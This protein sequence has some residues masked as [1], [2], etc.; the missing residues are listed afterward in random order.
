MKV[1]N[2]PEPHK[3]D[4]TVLFMLFLV[5][6]SFHL[7]MERRKS[8]V[9]II[10]L[11]LVCFVFEISKKKHKETSDMQIKLCFTVFGFKQ[12]ILFIQFKLCLSRSFVSGPYFVQLLCMC[13]EGMTWK[14]CKQSTHDI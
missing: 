11:G 14:C 10:S 6:T 13:R 7:Q 2:T 1:R 9:V 3:L 12:F 5:L 8:T 4:N